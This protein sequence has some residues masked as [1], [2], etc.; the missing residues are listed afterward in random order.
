MEFK[1]LIRLRNKLLL[2]AR[3]FHEANKDLGGNTAEG[4][5]YTFDPNCGRSRE[6]IHVKV[7]YG[8]RDEGTIRGYHNLNTEAL[9]K[10]IK[11][12]AQKCRY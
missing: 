3:E 1:E 5:T 9:L 10:F 8:T 12:R 7:F 6:I 11:K 4:E 2:A